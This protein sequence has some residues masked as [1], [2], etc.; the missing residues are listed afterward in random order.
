M[1]TAVATPE[2]LD[3]G[4]VIRDTFGVLRRNLVVFLGL[5]VLLGGVPSLVFQLASAP[6]AGQTAFTPGRLAVMGLGWL[7]AVAG[8]SI[9]QGAI[10]Y[11]AVTDLNGRRAGFLDCLRTG[12]RYF[13]PLLAI[14][15]LSGLGITVGFLLLFVPGAIVAMLWCVAGPSAVVENTG[16]FAAFTRSAALTKG[17]RWR[18]FGLFLL[19]GL[20]ILVVELAVYALVGGITAPV[21]LSPGRIAATTLIAIV[22]QLVTVTTIAALY[23]ELR[24][25]RDG[26]GAEALAA[27]FD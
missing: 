4:R 14:G 21:T 6:L 16:I 5:A 8:G 7:V 20:A 11:G 12:A 15:L 10:I 26:L 3:I 18:I 13:L 23:F 27:L 1:T 22:T 17:D 9:M 2:R 24:R 19:L 25:A